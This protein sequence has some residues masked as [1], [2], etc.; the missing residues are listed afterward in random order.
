[1]AHLVIRQAHSVIQ[2]LTFFLKYWHNTNKRTVS[3]KNFLVLVT[4]LTGIALGLAAYR[5]IGG[6][7]GIGAGILLGFITILTGFY[8]IKTDD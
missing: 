6:N 8:F 1:M 5:F 2:F 4:V 7:D 3:V